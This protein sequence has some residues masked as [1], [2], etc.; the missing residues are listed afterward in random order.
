MFIDCP[1]NT[2]Q[3]VKNIISSAEIAKKNGY[4][5]AIGHVGPAG[6]ITTAEAIKRAVP[7]I[8]KMGVKLVTVSELNEYVNGQQ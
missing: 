5:V 4:A 1:G 3:V 8:E 7:E 2:E 6:G